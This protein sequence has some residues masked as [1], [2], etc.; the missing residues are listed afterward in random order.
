MKFEVK[1]EYGKVLSEFLISMMI[2]RATSI[3]K[4]FYSKKKKNLKEPG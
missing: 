4:F 3:E 1:F 2:T